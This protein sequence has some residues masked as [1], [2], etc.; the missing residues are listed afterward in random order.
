MCGIGAIFGRGAERK[1]LEQMLT[2]I[3][4]R[5]SKT[6]EV[7]DGTAFAMGT[8]RLPIVDRLNAIQPATNERKTIFAILN[9][10]IFNY[11]TLKRDLEKGHKFSTDSDT[12]VLTHLYEEY[13]PTKEFLDLLDS[14]MYAFVIYDL[15]KN[16]VFAARD[17]FGVKPLYYA[18]DRDKGL[19]F[20]SE[21]KALSQFRDISDINLFPPAHFFANGE[22]HPYYELPNL[23]ANYNEEQTIERIRVLFEDAVRKRVDTDLPVGVFLSGGVDSSAVLAVAAKYADKK[24]LTA[25][26]IG[27]DGASDLEY[28]RKLC[29]GLGI[30][31]KELDP[32]NE[33]ELFGLIPHILRITESYEPNVVK[34]STLS[35]YISKIAK[36]ESVVLCGE[37][38]DEL[39][40]GYPEFIG[41]DDSDI[42]KRRMEF[43]NDLHRTQLQRVDR[44][45]MH[46]TTEVRAPFLD[47]ALADYALRVYPGH[48]IREHKGKLMAKLILRK[49]VE[50]FLPEEITWRP[51]VVLSEGAGYKGNDP[52]HGL[53][54]EIIERRMGNEEFERIKKQNQ[55]WVINTKEEAYYFKFFKRYRYTKADFNKERTRVNK[56]HTVIAKEVTEQRIIE[57]LGSKKYSK[58]TPDNL[59]KFKQIVGNAINEK[60]P[61]KTV[62]HWGY[63]GNIDISKKE[64]KSINF[65]KD[66][67]DEIKKI[68][69]PGLEVT[70][71][72]SDAHAEMNGFDTGKIKKYYKLIEA[73]FTENGFA[74]QYLSVLWKKWGI[75][76]TDIPK[77]QEESDQTLLDELLPSAS[78]YYHGPPEQG[79]KN[80]IAM[81]RLENVHLQE[82][83]RDVIYFTYSRPEIK[84]VLPDMPTIYFYS[85][86]GFAEPPWH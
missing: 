36:D 10:E 47:K 84:P 28:A 35:Y 2:S 62:L 29:A 60:K 19:Y 64:R 45:S 52:V 81:R 12:E 38:A 53:F 42:T 51:K 66:L 18:Y 58:T 74:V 68:Y 43:L 86:K 23:D 85:R 50:G 34:Q 79:V 39:F 31:L 76:K 73:V 57:L 11:K 46:F 67:I 77:M 25:Y 15:E 16:T 49:A 40:C 55:G 3:K 41:L 72:L 69:P 56:R 22:F 9:G 54:S 4:H 1:K 20:A 63:L 78:R 17:H 71:L 59:N 33:E 44:T 8:N 14:E 80:Y 27:K 61:I 37:G 21:I 82:N 32:P 70:I 83:F 75:G 26:A 24:R 7:S 6:L 13:G 5:G 30:T 48:F 65:L